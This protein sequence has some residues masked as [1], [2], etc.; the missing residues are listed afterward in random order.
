MDPVTIWIFCLATAWFIRRAVEDGYAAV[1]GRTSPRIARRQAAYE[2]AQQQ[3]A[4]TGTPTIGQAATG[5]LANRIANPRPPGPFRRYLSGLWEDSW[6]DA[7]ERREERRRR[8]AE[9]RREQA[10]RD[11]EQRREQAE[12]EAAGRPDPDD[13]LRTRKCR[14]CDVLVVEPLEWC[15]GCQSAE[16]RVNE[17]QPEPDPRRC[18]KCRHLVADVGPLDEVGECPDCQADTRDD[19]ANQERLADLDD[20]QVDRL[21]E[22]ASWRETTGGAQR[23]G[24]DHHEDQDGDAYYRRWE[25]P[26]PRVDGTLRTTVTS[27]AQDNGRRR[28]IVTETEWQWVGSNDDVLFEDTDVS[29]SS[30]DGPSGQPWPTP[31]DV[32]RTV[33]DASPADANETPLL[34]VLD[35]TLCP[36]GCGTWVVGGMCPTCEERRALPSAETPEPDPAPETTRKDTPPMSTPAE[37]NGDVS[38]PLDAL[39]FATSC[40]DLNAAIMNEL[41][42]MAN[43]LEGEGV[44]AACIQIVRDA[45]AAGDQFGTAAAGARDEYARHVATQ[46][47]IAGDTELR[48]TVAGTYLD[49]ARA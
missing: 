8:R 17:P 48:D 29:D 43:N 7:E 44:G 33:N 34:D 6:N 41:D 35:A 37:I 28:W 5:R 10:E 42:A 19:L 26:H 1:R 30:E 12:R 15:A 25:Q 24:G 49:A 47:E 31:D 46:A 14:G 27:W 2:L 22:P 36:G 3:A 32:R 16:R 18:T 13:A 11:A 21:N 38:S 40:L 23:D 45:W 9:Q 20:E 39:A 4:A